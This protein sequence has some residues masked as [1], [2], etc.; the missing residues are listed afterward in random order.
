M[1][2]KNFILYRSSAGSGKTY[3]LAREYLKLVIT[4]PDKYKNILAVTFTNKATQE[5]KDR[6]LHYLHAL[7]IGDGGSMQKELKRFSGLNEEEITERSKIALQNILHNYSYFSI[8]TI[9]SFFQ[10]IIRT[11]AREMGL[12]SGYKLEMDQE[13]V[14]SEVVEML[15][16]DIGENKSLKNWLVQFAREKVDAG[17]SWDI[18][19]DI[20]NLG[21]EIFK[22]EFKAIEK[23]ILKISEDPK[24]IGA[25][26][27]KLK[28]YK[29]DFEEKIKN[30]GIKACQIMQDFNLS[31]DDF[32]NKDRGVM[33]YLHR[34]CSKDPY[35]PH[36]NAKK[37]L[38]N[39]D[40]WY[41]KTSSKK[42]I[43]QEAVKSGLNEVLVEV[44]DQF[45][46]DFIKYLSAT[47]I[48]RFIYTFGI[49]TNIHQKLQEYR[50]Q[51][52]LLLISDATAFLKEIIAEN[53]A[54]FIYEKTGS[55]YKHFLIDEFQDTSKFQ[56][57]NFKPLI[58]NSIADGNPN[59][60]VGDIKQSIY[61]WRGGDWKLLLEQISGDVGENNTEVMNLNTN[62]RSK[63]NIIDFNNSLFNIAPQ[64]LSHVASLRLEQSDYILDEELRNNLIAE[65]GKISNAYQDVFQV[66]PEGII[67]EGNFCGYVNMTFIDSDQDLVPVDLENEEESATWEE[68]V[69][70]RIPPLLE[71]IQDQG[72]ALKDIAILVR[73]RKEGK[74]IA[75]C[76]LDYKNS[77]EAKNGY[78]YEVISS[79]ALFI[80]GATSTLL[81][82]NALR[83]INDVNDKIARVNLIYDYQRYILRNEWI[84]L[85]ELFSHASIYDPAHQLDLLPKEFI[86][87]QDYLGMLPLYELVEELIRIFD[88]SKIL[89]EIAYVQSLQDMVL[90]FMQEENADLNSFLEYWDDKG[91]S[92]SISISEK[93]NAVRI[94]TIH[95][96]KGLQ[97]KNVIVPYC[98]WKTDHNAT[99]DHFLW[100]ESNV[101]PFN[102]I[103][104]LPI[105]YGSV[106]EKT[107]Y[108]KAFFEEMVKAQM[109]YLNILYVAFTRAEE[110]LYA[111]GVKPKLQKGKIK[112]QCMSSL[113][114]YIFSQGY[115]EDKIQ[116]RSK[117]EE[118][119]SSLNTFWK[120]EQAVF[121][122]GDPEFKCH[123]EP[124]ISPSIAKSIV[125]YISEPWRNRISIKTRSRE[126][127][128]SDTIKKI[129]FGNLMHRV[130][131]KIKTSDQVDFVLNE[132]YFNGEIDNEDLDILKLQIHQILNNPT[133]K[134][135][136][137]EDWEIKTEAPVLPHSGDIKR[138]D[139]V[140]LRGREAIVVDFKSGFPY[141]SHKVQIKNYTHL[142]KEMDYSPV[143]G[144]L[145]YL[146][147]GV[148]EKVV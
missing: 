106:L 39:L 86:D 125:T 8:S 41:T 70:R 49:L 137:N 78:S 18:K 120:T 103:K 11:F 10:K 71:K 24:A 144:Y 14:L 51:H 45:E 79:E 108:Q 5:M 92:T 113:L 66:T 140:M 22:E 83:V 57:A 16:M 36:S 93:L 94:I 107:I 50:D 58:I 90:N 74:A 133:V 19:K 143:H 142:L 7:S 56:W 99:F 82:L 102:E 124:G 42:D 87:N 116:I 73:D 80:S 105:K 109:D 52:G 129:N 147:E 69:K 26:V 111:F 44:I 119:V 110:A 62:W 96:A 65:A 139:R 60:V 98:N 4:N 145:V 127:F 76:I 122:L 112:V 31:V 81:L 126:F 55:N 136:F 12:Q 46:K 34:L 146:A 128:S 85:H 17:K 2:P 64:V 9:D 63:K 27:G 141:D 148:V 23:D 100:C 3:T 59:L 67:T 47:Q 88:L 32:S 132:L 33:G 68:E 72:Y 1:L 75:S 101:S 134:G 118:L 123:K 43:I 61:R 95:K 38:H 54:P 53:D 40:G 97:F 21:N 84:D 104:F 48:L 37:A 25:Y 115:L 30:L 135:W 130:L 35:E 29:N 77:A 20:T 138:F 131:S 13:K 89:G 15:I 121:E 28:N 6:I 117:D 114:Y 91:C